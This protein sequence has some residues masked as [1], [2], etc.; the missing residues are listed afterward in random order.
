MNKTSPFV[1]AIAAAFAIVC[2]A[3]GASAQGGLVC[4]PGEVYQPPTATGPP[5]PGKCVPLPT[6]TRRLHEVQVD[7]PELTAAIEHADESDAS[8][9]T[10]IG[11]TY[12]IYRQTGA[13]WNVLSHSSDD[14]LT[15][16]ALNVAFPDFSVEYWITTFEA[17]STATLKN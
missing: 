10:A 5:G 17:N 1:L 15:F 9:Q 12:K 11:L 2:A 7:H 13:A 16:D 8:M 3:S 4:P 14:W 6:T